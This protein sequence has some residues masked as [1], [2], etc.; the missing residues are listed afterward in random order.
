[1][2]DALLA[3]CITTGLLLGTP[4]PATLSLAAT[5]ATFGIKRGAP[6]LIGILTGLLF[7]IIGASL[8]VLSLFEWYPS[9]R[10][11]MQWLGA[12]YIVYIAYRVATAPVID[13]NSEEAVAPSALDGFIL[14]LLNPK[15]Y[16]A[17]FAI[18]SQ[19][20]LP[21][22]SASVSF[23]VTALV[24]LGI[25]TLVDMIW[26]GAGSWLRPLFAHP[27]YAKRLRYFFALL[28]VLSVGYTLA[29]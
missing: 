14:N 27:T 18:F 12:G 10:T 1:M 3:L 2:F 25:A 13:T 7:V 23:L 9:L 21:Y 22:S 20:T 29:S 26:L 8:G 11:A 6:F 16:A 5:G 17:F 24:C 15:A 28:M 19:F 4:G